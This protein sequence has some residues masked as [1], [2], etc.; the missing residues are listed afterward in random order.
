MLSVVQNS[1]PPPAASLPHPPMRISPRQPKRKL[2]WRG[3]APQK[4]FFGRACGAV[5]AQ[6]P[7]WKA[8]CRFS[9]ASPRPSPGWRDPPLDRCPGRPHLKRLKTA[10]RPC[11]GERA[12]CRRSCAPPPCA[13]TPRPIMRAPWPMAIGAR[14]QRSARRS[15]P[16]CLGDRA[17]VVG[18]RRASRRSTGRISRGPTTSITPA[19][20]R[21]TRRTS[22]L[23]APAAS[24]STPLASSIR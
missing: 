24:C 18:R 9:R 23:R 11:W 20:R 2:R 8:R 12:G 10:G 4:I 7:A 3:E 14:I 21:A 22:T 6:L 16:M 1:L 19:S 5:R 13:A 17:T 15:Q